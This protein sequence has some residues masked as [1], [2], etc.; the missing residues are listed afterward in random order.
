VTNHG[1]LH[2]WLTVYRLGGSMLT[3]AATASLLAALVVMPAGA[4]TKKGANTVTYDVTITADGSAYTGTMAL[5]IGSGKVSGDMHITAPTEITGKPAGIAKGG[6][7]DLDFPYRMVQRA[8]DGRIAMAIALPA[9]KDAAPASGTVSI[10][11][12]GSAGADR[13][14]GTIELKPQAAAKKK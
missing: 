10:G 5:A 11:R 3:H 1:N 14:Q 6:K 4:Q 7:L 9:K 2:A 13:I 12:C 8:C